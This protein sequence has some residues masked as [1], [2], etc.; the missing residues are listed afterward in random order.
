M[1]KSSNRLL[2]RYVHN[3]WSCDV[4]GNV[5]ICA[6][7]PGIEPQQ[8]DLFVL[9]SAL[10]IAEKTLKA[11]NMMV[12]Q[13]GGDPTGMVEAALVDGIATAAADVGANQI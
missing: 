3:P 4:A 1:E 5:D 11:L 8:W 13:M 2:A 9:V 10:A 6:D 7:I 12:G